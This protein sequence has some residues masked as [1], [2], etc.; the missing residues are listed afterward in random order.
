MALAFEI[1]PARLVVTRP[2]VNNNHEK[3]VERQRRPLEPN[4]ASGPDA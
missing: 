1:H 3:A 4:H 2:V